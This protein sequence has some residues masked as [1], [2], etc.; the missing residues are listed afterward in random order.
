MRQGCLIVAPLPIE[1]GTPFCVAGC[2]MWGR[3]VVWPRPPVMSVNRGARLC[4]ALCVGGGPL[5]GT[6]GCCVRR[7]GINKA[8]PGGAA[9]L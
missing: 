8:A 9:W 2:R 4:P 5:M 6:G 3:G 7:R 1:A